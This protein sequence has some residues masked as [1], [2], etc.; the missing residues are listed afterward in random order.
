M[1]LRHL[2]YFVAV[3]EELHFAR[4]AER[5]HI[6]QSPLSRAIKDLED[7]LGVQ[8]FERTTR[9]TRMTWA[10]EVMLQDARRILA[11]VDQARTKVRA[12]ARGGRSQLRIGLTDSLSQPRL[13]RLSAHFYA[14]EPELELRL[15]EM[16]FSQQLMGLRN[17][18][19]DVGFAWGADVG[20]G[21]IA[22]PIWAEPIEIVLPVGHRLATQK[23]VSLADAAR[24][25]LILANPEIE[26]GCRAQYEALL[27]GAS[28]GRALNIVDQVPSRGMLITL[29]ATGRGIGFIIPSQ[30]EEVVQRADIVGLPLVEAPTITTYALRRNEA[31][32]Q[33]LGRFLEEARRL[34]EQRPATRSAA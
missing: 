3:A 26:P 17:D 9:G 5:L 16:S 30:A 4:A 19:L 33:P 18:L 28:G 24:E 13:A 23:I 34:A 29:V 22:E 27:S 12:A 15:F 14:T 31:V 32:G 20:D 7:D 10:G 2:R 21:I 1:E 6:D 25:P 8:L 11:A